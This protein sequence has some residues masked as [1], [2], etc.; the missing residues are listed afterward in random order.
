MV[1][2]FRLVSDEARSFKREIQIDAGATFLDLRN[3]ICDAV[4]FRKDEPSTFYLCEDNWEKEKAIT[5][6]DMGTDSSEDAYLMDE[7]VLEDYIED[8]G[9]KLMYTFDFENDR[10][11]FLE[12]NKFITGRS[13]HEPLCT[14]ALGKAPLQ[15]LPQELPDPAPKAKAAAKAGAIDDDFDDPILEEEGFNPD[16]FDQEG[17]S[18][19]NM[20][21]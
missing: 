13:L 16:E 14:L 9:Q 17:F 21:E 2:N 1:F 19:M 10:S 20:D 15:E 6:E 4:G 11:F 7:C 8:E 12:M 5:L 3:A 18:E